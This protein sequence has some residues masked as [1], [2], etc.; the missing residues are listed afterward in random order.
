MVAGS[1]E[2][3][4]R[5]HWV[6]GQGR[7]GMRITSGID[8]IDSR[9]QWS[10]VPAGPDVTLRRIS[11]RRRSAGRRECGAGGACRLWSDRRPASATRRWT[12]PHSRGPG[13]P[14][15]PPFLALDER[16]DSGK[17]DREHDLAAAGVRGAFDGQASAGSTACD[18]LDRGEHRVVFR[19]STAHSQSD[20][21]ATRAPGVRLYERRARHEQHYA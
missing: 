7:V 6:S 4:Q 18:L 15:C 14:L 19:T 1:T 5:R 2:N 8:A 11:S 17:R 16:A 12:A 21:P 13:A 20:G 10:G 9:G 3:H